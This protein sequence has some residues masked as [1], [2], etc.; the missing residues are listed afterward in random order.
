MPTFGVRSILRWLSPAAK[1]K[2]YVYEERIT[3]WNA[4]TILEAI[5]LAE[6][7]AEAY[8]GANAKRL[9]LL[10][11][12][13]LCDELKLK[14]QGIEVFS[15]LRESDLAPKAYLNAFFDSGYERETK[16]S[17]A[18]ERPDRRR[19]TARTPRSGQQ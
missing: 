11:G 18:P 19:R 13:L 3:I 10:Q 9:G 6:E 17:V 5:E 12:F 8:G 4:S 1:R 16:E 15:L 14:K 2:K 7:E